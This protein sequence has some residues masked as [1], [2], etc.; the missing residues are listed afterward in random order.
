MKK[1]FKLFLAI[2]TA[3]FAIGL[4]S[5]G[6]PDAPEGMQLAG[7]G[8]GLG[9]KFFVP[10]EW[11]VSSYG[12]F[13]CAYVSAVNNT[14]VAF[15][16]A[17]IPDY[18][19]DGMDADEM[20]KYF[21]ERMDNL[22]YMKSRK[23]MV[24]AEKCAFGNEQNAYKFVY[25]YDY[26]QN[27]GA[28]H[29]QAMQILIERGG[30]LYIFQYNSQNSVPQYSADGKTTHYEIY[31]EKVNEIITSFV[32]EKDPSVKAPDA[33][34][35]STGEFV[36]VSDPKLCDFDFY[37]PKDSLPIASSSLVHR[38]LGGGA[39]VS[40]SELMLDSIPTDTEFGIN[41]YWEG[42]KANFEKSYGEIKVLSKYKSE[43]KD[44]NG[45]EQFPNLLNNINGANGGRYYE[46]EYN[47]AEKT[48]RSYMV[49]IGI[50]D[51][52]SLDYYI[53]T[54]QAPVEA[55]DKALCDKILGK[56]EFK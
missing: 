35:G 31:L 53:Y 22:D 38:D 23:L 27:G 4:S 56:V 43:G 32:F 44:E 55:Y 10:E 33:V 3:A 54:Y 41:E 52:F 21:N 19:K 30:R 39:T 18:G 49:I 13:D 47:Y 28:I 34:A 45:K 29:Y 15:G 16:E 7:G 17:S 6:D 12:E 37:A 40:L 11:V 25:T 9:Y 48:Y 5:C 50:V 42:L 1:T 24:D 14:S 20:R 51:T 36:L 2:I 46:Y 8:D 26:P